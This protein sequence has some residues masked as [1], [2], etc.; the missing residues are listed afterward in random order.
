MIRKLFD[1][2]LRA[3]GCIAIVGI[4]TVVVMWTPL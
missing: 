1:I 4:C 2:A 3:L